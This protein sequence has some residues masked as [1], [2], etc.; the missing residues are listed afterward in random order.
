MRSRVYDKVQSRRG[1]RLPSPTLPRLRMNPS[2]YCHLPF[3]LIRYR[4]SSICRSVS[5]ICRHPPPSQLVGCSVDSLTPSTSLA[6]LPFPSHMPD[7]LRISV[8][9][10][11]LYRNR[12]V[13]PHS[14]VGCRIARLPASDSQP[15]LLPLMPLVASLRL[16]VVVWHHWPPPFVGCCL[17]PPFLSHLTRL[18][19]SAAAAGGCRRE[20]RRQSRDHDLYLPSS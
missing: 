13:A 12:T 2:G 18:R 6:S 16:L 14:I 3:G 1:T 10:S 15:A 11:A 17:W 4:P 9:D 20:R 5:S 7:S 19:L 8:G